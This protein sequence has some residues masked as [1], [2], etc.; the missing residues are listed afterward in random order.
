[1]ENLVFNTELPC[2]YSH[3]GCTK[4]F[5]G[6]QRKEHLKICSF[7]PIKCPFSSAVLPLFNECLYSTNNIDDLLKHVEKHHQFDI[8]QHRNNEFQFQLD[9]MKPA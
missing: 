3:N 6:K 7:K 9:S 2:N 1:M 4:V 8:F 5:S